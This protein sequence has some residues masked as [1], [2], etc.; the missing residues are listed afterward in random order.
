M[1]LKNRTKLLINGLNQEKI[2]NELSKFMPIYNYKRLSFKQSEF[3]IDS[4]YL[5]Q[6]R[7]IIVSYGFVIENIQ[8]YGVIF[9]IKSLLKRYG[10]FAGIIVSLLFYII[11]YNFVWTVNAVGEDAQQAQQIENYVKKN[12]KSN[13]KGNIDTDS[14]ESELRNQF[15]FVS[16]VSVAIIGQ[17]LVINFNEAVLP[18]EMEDEKSP[19]ISQFD[20][21]ITEIN[22]I[23]GTLNCSEGDIVQK[24]DILVYPYIIDSQGQQ[25]SVEPKAEIYAQVWYRSSID[26]YE[27]RIETKR[28]GNVIIKN[29]V[30]IG[31]LLL[32]SDSSEISYVQYDS[33]T[34]T[35]TLSKN[36]LLPLSLKKTIYYETVTEEI[37][38]DFESVKEQLISKARENTLLFLQKDEIIKDEN[39]TLT[40]GAGCHTIT[41]TISVEKDIAKVVT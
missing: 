20:G 41:Y 38:E 24:G 13:F 29:D 34:T 36:L 19:I 32:Y 2:L 37:I 15:D 21:L 18:P 8:N 6:A 16:S 35:R 4:R 40:G 23:Q 17:S 25:M 33:E 22:L 31:G 27:Y 11:Q 7:K 14:I 39:Y 28:T 1:K 26:H 10:V 12:L 3:E 30:Y 9:W 5:K